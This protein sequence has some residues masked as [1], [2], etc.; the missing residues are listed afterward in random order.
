MKRTPQPN[1]TQSKLTSMLHPQGKQSEAG[2]TSTA[3]RRTITLDEVE[4][5]MDTASAPDPAPPSTGG[6]A[7]LTVDL[8]LKAMK[9]NRDDIIS[10]FNASIGTLSRR[11]EDNSAL[12][13][14]NSVAIKHQSDIAAGHKSD[15]DKLAERVGRLERNPGAAR[16]GPIAERRAVLSRDFMLARRSIRLWPIR[17]DDESAMWEEVGDFLHDTLAIRADNVGQN[18]I[19]SV[20]RVQ[21]SGIV[22]ENGEA[23][24]TFFDKKKRD[25]VL[26]HS[27]SLAS[28][29][30]SDNRPTAGIRLEIP[31]ELNDTFRLLTRFGARLRARHGA[32]TQRHIKFD[33][34]NASLFVNVKLPG[35]TDWTRVTAAMAREDL[36]ASIREEGLATQKRLAT[37]LMPGPRERLSRPMASRTVALSGT[38]SSATPIAGPSGKRPRWSVPDRR[39]K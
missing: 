11:I 20:S 13:S 8:F 24:I 34:F 14:A 18:D 36:D 21:G 23:L 33:D 29:V 30:D 6:S 5:E 7:F 25:L 10:S 16:G 39:D 12:I 22:A 2:D 15:L 3:A 9:E 1:L 28:K 32:G 37:K 26:T 4:D 38:S 27:P 31:P 35:D 19:E 17:G